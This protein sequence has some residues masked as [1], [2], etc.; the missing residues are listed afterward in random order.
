MKVGNW[1][2]FSL[3][4]HDPSFTVYSLTFGAV[5][6]STTVIEVLFVPTTFAFTLMSAQRSGSTPGYSI[7]GLYCLLCLWVLFKKIATV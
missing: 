7:K 4:L 6:V 5:P 1:K 3:P 2:Q